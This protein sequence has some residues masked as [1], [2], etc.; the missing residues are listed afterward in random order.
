MG[1]EIYFDPEVKSIDNYVINNEIAA[2]KYT[3]KYKTP[4]WY[5][6]NKNY[7]NNSFLFNGKYVNNLYPVVS[8]VITT[9]YWGE[10]GWDIVY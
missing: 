2:I 10:K 1:L 5:D 3:V 9:L 6:K 7:F 4:L 8:G